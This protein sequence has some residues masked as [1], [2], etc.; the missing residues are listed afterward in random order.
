MTDIAYKFT[1]SQEQLIV[2]TTRVESMPND[3]AVAVYPD[4]PRYSHLTEAFGTAVAKITP[5]HDHLDLEIAQT[6]GLK[7]ITV[8]DEDGRM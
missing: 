3:V 5:V 7:L 8:I 6:K 4:D 2:S 1:D